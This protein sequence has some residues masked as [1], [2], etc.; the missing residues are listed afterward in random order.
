MR[1]IPF[2]LIQTSLKKAAHRAVD[3]LLPKSCTNCNELTHDDH[4][5]CGSCYSQFDFI[6]DPI[7][8]CCGSPFMVDLYLGHLCD[9]CVY[10]RP[11][12]DI[13]RSLLKFNEASKKL[14]HNFKFN[15]R[16]KNAHFFA[17]LLVSRYANEVKETD[18]IAPVPMYKYKRL[19]RMYNPPQILA[20]SLA[21]HLHNAQLIPDLLLK[22]KHT[23]SQHKLTQ[24]ERYKNLAGSISLNSKFDI[25]GKTILLVD[26]VQTTGTTGNYCAKVLS[27]GKPARIIFLNI[28]RT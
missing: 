27:Q 19:L 17:R 10:E 9:R 18:I 12:Y 16:L 20:M 5:L 7:C 1:Y 2:S 6:D 22:I 21:R 11:I 8:Y 3:Y 13:G 4:A 25:Q 24:K 26:D 23:P 28:A 15:D 14:I